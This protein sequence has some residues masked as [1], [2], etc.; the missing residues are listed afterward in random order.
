MSGSKSWT[1]WPWWVPSKSVYSVI[2]WAVGGKKVN[3]KQKQN[4]QKGYNKS[5]KKNLT[6]K[7]FSVDVFQNNM[8]M[9]SYTLLQTA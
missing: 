7:S 3:G 2:L 6:K 9:N 5:T 1:Q 8:D 4:P